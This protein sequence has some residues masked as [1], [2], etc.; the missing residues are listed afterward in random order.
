[1][2]IQ[3]LFLFRS[4]LDGLRDDILCL[5]DDGVFGLLC[6]PR[7]RRLTT[8]VAVILVSRLQWKKV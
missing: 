5:L 8:S 7:E 3:S 1:M 4:T 6:L 2:F